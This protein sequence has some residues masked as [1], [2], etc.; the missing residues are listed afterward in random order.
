M[1]I[2]K[3]S[4]TLTGTIEPDNIVMA[5]DYLQNDDMTQYLDPNLQEVVE[6]IQ[7][8]LNIDGHT[9]FVEAFAT[10][11]L[12]EVELKQMSDWVSGQN[13]DGLGEGFEQ[14]E[15]A[16]IRGD[17]DCGCPWYT[18]CGCGSFEDGGM[19]SFDWQTN[20]CTFERIK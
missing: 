8:T 9:W 6:R 17:R 19:I 12:T 16:E 7:W 15:F 3:T 14:Q 13:S 10:R 4:G 18:T 11:E 20:D 2:Y 1:P 5:Q